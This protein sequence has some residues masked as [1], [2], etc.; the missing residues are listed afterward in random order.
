[1]NVDLIFSFGFEL[2][3][4]ERLAREALRT[5]DGPAAGRLRDE[6]PFDTLLGCVAMRHLLDLLTAAYRRRDTAQDTHGAEHPGG[7]GEETLPG[8]ELA[9]Q[10]LAAQ[11]DDPTPAVR[12]MLEAI[13]DAWERGDPG[14]A[15]HER[16][17]IDQV[18]YGFEAPAD[19]A[20]LR[21]L[22]PAQRL[23]RPHP[24]LRVFLHAG[25]LNGATVSTSR[26][27]PPRDATPA[28]TCNI[29]LLHSAE[30]LY[31]W[32]SRNG[33]TTSLCGSCFAWWMQRAAENEVLT[34]APAGVRRLDGTPIPDGDLEVLA[35][36]ERQAHP[37]PRDAPQSPLPDVARTWSVTNGDRVA[38]YAALRSGAVIATPE[39]PV[40]DTPGGA[41]NHTT[42][43]H[44]TQPGAENPGPSN[45]TP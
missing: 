29:G 39:R 9:V 45:Y 8:L 19:I 28:R 33:L 21:E 37:H 42:P 34:P 15:S 10:T 43:D 2:S 4:R 25:L 40:G 13:A 12:R 24:N 18:G 30:A 16:V 5:P 27:V 26:A 32:R 20:P 22:T 35:M 38:F 6:A 3:K 31:E 41:P 14:P 17:L 7:P 1:M 44:A 36:L 23:F 11:F